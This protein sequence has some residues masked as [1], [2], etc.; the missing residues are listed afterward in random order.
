MKQIKLETHLAS[1]E[2]FEG[3]AAMQDIIQE[4]LK[5]IKVGL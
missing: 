2:H 4:E 3:F 1:F 5:N